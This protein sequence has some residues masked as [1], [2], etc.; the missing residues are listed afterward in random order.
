MENLEITPESVETSDAIKFAEATANQ[1][2]LHDGSGALADQREREKRGNEAR[3]KIRKVLGD[4]RY[5]QFVQDSA[6]SRAASDAT[7]KKMALENVR[8]YQIQAEKN[9]L[10]NRVTATVMK[11]SNECAAGVLKQANDGS[12]AANAL[13]DKID[14]TTTL[15]DR[16]IASID[17]NPHLTKDEKDARKAAI[18]AAVVAENVTNSAKNGEVMQELVGRRKNLGI[19]Q[20]EDMVG[21]V[22]DVFK[23]AFDASIA[24]GH[25]PETS[26]AH[27]VAVSRQFAV[28]CMKSRLYKGQIEETLAGIDYLTKMDAELYQKSTLKI[29]PDGEPEVDENGNQIHEEGTV[30]LSR[31]LF[32]RPS[33]FDE[34]KKLGQ[35]II[36]ESL[37]REKARIAAEKL[38]LGLDD[39]SLNREA[40]A[41]ELTAKEFFRRNGNVGKDPVAAMEVFIGKIDELKAKGYKDAGGLYDRIFAAA[42]KIITT[43]ENVAKRYDAQTNEQNFTE[44]KDRWEL[45]TQTTADKV[46]MSFMVDGRPIQWKDGVDPRDELIAMTR[47]ALKDGTIPDGQKA[48]YRERLKELEADKFAQDEAALVDI[49]RLAGWTLPTS[50]TKDVL[51]Y[52][53]GMYMQVEDAPSNQT[54]DSLLFNPKTMNILMGANMKAQWSDGQTSFELGKNET[55]EVFRRMFKIVAET[56]RNE[57][58]DPKAKQEL[59]GKFRTMCA[60]VARS[61]SQTER[62]SALCN[63]IRRLD[64]ATF[65]TS[66]PTGSFRLS[67]MTQTYIRPEEHARWLEAQK[68]LR[69]MNRQ[70]AEGK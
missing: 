56:P 2:L 29:G 39:D 23:Q 46:A 32:C 18:V 61:A 64:N 30:D 58:L 28:D 1:L 22:K 21:I 14:E 48:E 70:R 10:E 13:A 7:F 47:H 6:P 53:E 65:D 59:A 8:H 40:D 4:D 27:A 26:R 44:F 66:L 60:N 15:S 33:D 68:L 45:L 49:A 17:G 9:A 54:S 12:E 34:I 41:I 36:D 35:G 25:D 51:S 16:L 24:V 42:D 52:R 37:R 3:A 20:A 55:Q 63:G 67:K 62:L 38:K 50:Q 57:F 11:Y 19:A 31:T 5:E 69:E 43:R